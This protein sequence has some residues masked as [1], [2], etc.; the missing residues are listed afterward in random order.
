MRLPFI[1]YVVITELGKGD[2]F[3]SNY[4]VQ[5]L[6]VIVD[7]TVSTLWRSAD[8]CS[9]GSILIKFSCISKSRKYTVTF[10]L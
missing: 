5:Q 7:F 9:R 6:T 8:V 2:N 4:D 1:S 10:V 3:F